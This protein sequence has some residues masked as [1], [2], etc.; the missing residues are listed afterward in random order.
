MW[1]KVKRTSARVACAPASRLPCAVG[2]GGGGGGA[3]RFDC[4]GGG[5]RAQA[6][7]TKFR[8]IYN[9]LLLY[10]QQFGTLDVPQLYAVPDQEPWPQEW[11]GMKVSAF[12]SFFIL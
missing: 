6:T 10:Q 7:E 1:Y 4:G 11:W 3:W 2:C 8:K 9:A 12:Y 5:T